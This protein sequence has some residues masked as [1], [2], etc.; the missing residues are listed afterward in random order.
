MNEP[1]GPLKLLVL[2]PTSLCNLDCRY[3]Y[4]PDRTRR[5]QMDASLLDRIFDRVL[6]SPFASGPFSLLWHAGEPLLRPPSF[7]DQAT[8]RLHEALRRHGWPQDAVSQVVQTNATVLNDAWAACLIRNRI[9]V[10]VSLDGPAWLHDRE[11]RSRSGAGSHAA[12]LHG[13]E[14]L[15]RH[16]IPFSVIAVVT[17]ASLDHADALFE[18]FRSIG[19][20]EVGLN[21]EER[22]GVNLRSSLELQEGGAPAA[23]QHLERRYIR[24]LER[25]W[26]RNQAAGRPLAIRE[27]ADVMQLA[28]SGER[29][30]R[31]DLNH[32][33]AIVNVDHQGRFSTFDPELLG[34]D[35]PHGSWVLGHVSDTSL[36]DSSRNERFQ[37]QWQAVQQGVEQCRLQCGHFGLCGGGACSNKVWENGTAASAETQA[38]RYRIKLASEVVLQRM[39]RELELC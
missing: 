13:V 16:G 36:E 24:F 19:A 15:Q 2:Q 18:F 39:E 12:A 6:E 32:P 28:L 35:T 7:Y 22:E 30:G 5:L 9:D 3:C 34:V 25:L 21:M 4:L 1:F 8:A 17:E 14:C 11:R 26:D 29:I 27:F 10:G 20:E 31:N 37:R 38:C 33:F 23:Q